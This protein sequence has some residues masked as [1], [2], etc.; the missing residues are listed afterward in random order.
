MET[1]LL[2]PRL[3]KGQAAPAQPRSSRPLQA[4]Q[5][6]DTW[7]PELTSPERKATG[8]HPPPPTSTHNIQS[9][10][11]DGQC[12]GN[13]RAHQSQISAHFLFVVSTHFEHFAPLHV[14]AP[15]S[16]ALVKGEFSVVP[17]SFATHATD[18]KLSGDKGKTVQ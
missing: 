2:P 12:F 15:L 14:H 11:C 5:L 7:S 1:Q 3:A 13:T 8:N 9:C 17:P 18:A 4:R 16:A 6:W 10:H